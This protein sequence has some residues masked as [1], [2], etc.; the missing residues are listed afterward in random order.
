MPAIFCGDWPSDQAFAVDWAFG[1]VLL[2]WMELWELM[3]LSAL[4]LPVWV[5]LYA[6]R[7]WDLS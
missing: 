7:A 6:S 1:M 3:D 4:E 2:E 5:H